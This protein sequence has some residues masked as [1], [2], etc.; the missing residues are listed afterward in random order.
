MAKT[1]RRRARKG[2]PTHRGNKK[3]GRVEPSRRTQAALAAY[4]DR[5][6]TL[7]EAAKRAGMSPT[8]L[9]KLAKDH[10]VALRG[11]GLG[12]GKG[13]GATAEQ[14]AR[15]KRLYEDTKVWHTL[16][17]IERA[18]G[19]RLRQLTSLRR[20]DGW[21]RRTRTEN[22]SPG[23]KPHQRAAQRNQVAKALQAY[24]DP[25]I[26]V[27]LAAERSGLSQSTLHKYAASAGLPP[28]AKG[29]RAP[30]TNEQVADAKRLWEDTTHWYCAEVIAEAVG[31]TQWQIY[32][33]ARRGR[34]SR[35]VV[36]PYG[37]R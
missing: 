14:T 5:N 4:S 3:S 24:Q 13:P 1:T 37:H 2:M 31:M 8:T 22:A 18:T 11:R 9:L 23:G 21:Q 16:E 7:V 15:A 20:R 17:A 10:G 19:L 12:R 30:Y 27:R 32:Y 34:W 29:R 36:S 6:L 28:R 35:G 25:S 26:S 33:C